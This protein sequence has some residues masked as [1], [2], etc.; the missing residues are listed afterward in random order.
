MEIGS[1]GIVIRG[2]KL[3]TKTEVDEVA[4][5]PGTFKGTVIVA[6]GSKRAVVRFNDYGQSYTAV[7]DVDLTL[8]SD[9]EWPPYVAKVNKTKF[10][11][12][13]TRKVVADVSIRF[14]VEPVV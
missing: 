6:R 2:V 4:N 8:L 5:P 10:V 13:F 7:P 3:A 12:R 14:R 1:A 11:I 9:S